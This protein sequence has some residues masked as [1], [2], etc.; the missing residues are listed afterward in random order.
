MFHVFHRAHFFVSFLFDVTFHTVSKC[1]NSEDNHCFFERMKRY[2]TV[3]VTAMKRPDTDTD[4]DT[5][6]DKSFSRALRRERHLTVRKTALQWRHD[7]ARKGIAMELSAAG[8]DLIKRSEG[9]RSCTYLDVT[10]FPTI[11]YGHKLLHPESFPQ[12][13][14]EAQASAILA[15]DVCGAEQAVARLAKVPLTQGQFDALVDFVFNL[16]AGRLA[17]STLLGVLN[18]GEYDEAARQILRWDRAGGQELSAL[19]ARRQAEVVLW[20]S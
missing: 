18:R 12:G 3:S 5:D 20:N 10:G 9:F 1:L 13:I 4:T 2:K 11:G 8:L 6:T 17:Q 14:D 16:G 15:S 7:P 19:K